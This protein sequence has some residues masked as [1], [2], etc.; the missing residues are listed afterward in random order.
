[1]KIRDIASSAALMVIIALGGLAAS[2]SASAEVLLDETD[3]PAAGLV[4]ESLSFTATAPTTTLYDKGYQLPGF[5]QFTDNS[6]TLTAGGPNLL[7][8]VWGFIPAP[9]G[10]DT[11]QYND[12]TS[13]NAL[14]FGGVTV[15]S[16]DTYFQTFATVPGESY[17][18]TFNFVQND[19]PQNGYI[20]ETDSGGVPEPSAW[21]L[22]V[23]GIGGI[24]LLM[25]HT[26]KDLGD[27][28]KG[29]FAE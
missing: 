12:G 4:P 23:A 21:L 24:G 18:Y 28:F 10:S 2:G 1:M 26:K 17:T 6:V 13:V 8:Q 3:I 15:G 11:S 29:R 20:V 27:R 7:Q 25:R 16:N 9:S 19:P 14:N 5:D 22:M